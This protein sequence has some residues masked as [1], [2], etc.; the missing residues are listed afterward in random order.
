MRGADDTTIYE[1]NWMVRET[2]IYFR[3]RRLSYWL[4]RGLYAF[5]VVFSIGKYKILG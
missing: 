1:N 3:I 4:K 5:P 2:E